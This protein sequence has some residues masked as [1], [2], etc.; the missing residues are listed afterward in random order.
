M[1]MKDLLHPKGILNSRL[2]VP[3]VKFV[4]VAYGV[5]KTTG[6]GSLLETATK[7]LLID[8]KAWERWTNA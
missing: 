8:A 1:T 7:N 4:R 5:R 3:R 6:G 2:S